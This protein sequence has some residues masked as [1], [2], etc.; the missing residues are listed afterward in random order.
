MI[1]SGQTEDPT[2]ADTSKDAALKVGEDKTNLLLPLDKEQ[3]A[4]GTMVNTARSEIYALHQNVRTTTSFQSHQHLFLE[5][6]RLMGELSDLFQKIFPAWR[7]CDIPFTT[8][9]H[10]QDELVELLS[11]QLTHSRNDG[12][13][14]DVQLVTAKKIVAGHQGR[15][16]FC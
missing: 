2:A 11:E 4:W 13:N 8:L 14:Q 15:T 6:T 5:Q 7:A 9:L 16:L 3:E 10:D 1:F 12:L